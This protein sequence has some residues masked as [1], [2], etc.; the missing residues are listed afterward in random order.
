M[1][2][3]HGKEAALSDVRPQLLLWQ[4]D[5]GIATAEAH[6]VRSSKLAFALLD[7]LLFHAIHL[8]DGRVLHEPREEVYTMHHRVVAQG[9]RQLHDILDLQN[10]PPAP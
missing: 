1:H 9:A 5:V 10:T 8:V 3:Q 6:D 7:L 4:V 2:K